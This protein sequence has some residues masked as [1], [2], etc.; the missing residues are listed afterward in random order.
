MLLWLELDSDKEGGSK[1][2]DRGRLCYLPFSMFAIRRVISRGDSIEV[3][4]SELEKQIILHELDIPLDRKG[5][6]NHVI[7]N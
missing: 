2:L 5:D 3:S 6:S 4:L 7:I 1:L